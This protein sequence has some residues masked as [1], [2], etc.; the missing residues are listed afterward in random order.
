MQ[1]IK[2]DKVQNTRLT[3]FL[4]ESKLHAN[5]Y[6]R[7]EIKD[8]LSQITKMETRETLLQELLEHKEEY[9]RKAAQECK[10]NNI[11]P[12]I[13]I[14]R[15]EITIPQYTVNDDRCTW[16]GQCEKPNH[17]CAKCGWVRYCSKECNTA[18]WEFGHKKACKQMRQMR[19]DI[20]SI[21][22]K[23]ELPPSTILDL[24]TV[25]AVTACPADGNITVGRSTGLK[26]ATIRLQKGVT[27]SYTFETDILT[28]EEAITVPQGVE[29]HLLINLQK[30][31][32]EQKSNELSILC[33]LYEW[34]G[35]HLSPCIFIIKCIV[36]NTVEYLMVYI[37]KEKAV[38]CVCQ[39]EKVECIMCNECTLI[40]TCEKCMQHSYI[41]PFVSCTMTVRRLN[42]GIKR[43]TYHRLL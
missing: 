16:C 19:Q 7:K 39:N 6:E 36:K 24:Q 9:I 22:A 10:D 11:D 37:Q 3:R 35:T 5:D 25:A 17:Y 27:N 29:L 32:L 21:A 13:L 40:E 28:K 8:M 26:D 31:K 34:I 1:E 33:N 42:Q 12:S 14:N 43:L 2:E 18:G 23:K 38:C 20:L 41:H 30:L 15:F 4:I